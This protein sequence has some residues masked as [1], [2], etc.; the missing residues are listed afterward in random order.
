MT[1][2]A[3]L[4]NARAVAKRKSENPVEMQM[5]NLLAKEKASLN[6]MISPYFETKS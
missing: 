2:I 3:R 4:V 5:T 6:E 1:N